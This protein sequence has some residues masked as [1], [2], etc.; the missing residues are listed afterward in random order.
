MSSQCSRKPSECKCGHAGI[1]LSL[2][3]FL[4]DGREIGFNDLMGSCTCCGLPYVDV[5]ESQKPGEGK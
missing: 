4:S 5:K 1:T 3:P 2:A